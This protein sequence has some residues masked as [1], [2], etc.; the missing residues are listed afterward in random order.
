MGPPQSQ[1]AGRDAAVQPPRT[2][3]AAALVQALEAAGVLVAAVLAAVDAGTGHAY[4]LASGIAISVIGFCTAIALAL[5][6]RSLRAGRR[7]TRTPAMLTQ[8]FIG[9]VGI[10]LVQSRRL[11]WGIPALLLAVAGF[12]AILA[13]A[14]LELLTPGRADKSAKK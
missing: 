14:S 7:W 13:P 5:V 4:H 3:L 11:D 6:A 9:I 8:L 10:Y 1:A 12:A 2:V